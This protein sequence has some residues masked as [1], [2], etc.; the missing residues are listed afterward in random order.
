[1]E[2]NHVTPDEDDRSSGRHLNVEH[3]QFA[4]GDLLPERIILSVFYSVITVHLLTVTIYIH[5]L[6]ATLFKKLYSFFKKMSFVT[7]S[8][9]QNETKKEYR[10]VKP[11]CTALCYSL[12]GT[13]YYTRLSFV[14]CIKFCVG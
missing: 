13:Q 11:F 7:K 9:N 1:M 8:L 2:A 14:L 4:V 12:H 6:D 3:S 5:Q 10:N